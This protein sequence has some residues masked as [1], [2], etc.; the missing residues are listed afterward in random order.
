MPVSL[1]RVEGRVKLDL[2]HFKETRLSLLLAHL[3]REL[4]I[5]TYV[6]FCWFQ[7]NTRKLGLNV[8]N[9]DAF[10]LKSIIYDHHLWSPHRS[11][12]G[13]SHQAQSFV[14]CKRED[15]PPTIALWW[16]NR[17]SN[18]SRAK[19]SWLLTEN[20]SQTGINKH[21]ERVFWERRVLVIVGIW[22]QIYSHVLYT[23]HN[24]Y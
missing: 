3:L 7:F 10:E 1:W 6:S 13:N 23:E 11:L 9:D 24:F 16:W 21:R 5:F 17:P 8:Q 4:G 18:Y 19:I 15:P 2:D 12:W 14:A 20:V 22:E